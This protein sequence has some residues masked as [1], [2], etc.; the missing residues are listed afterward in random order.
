[1]ATTRFMKAAGVQM[2]RV[3]YRGAAQLM[4]DLMASR[5]QLNFGPLPSGLAQAREGKLRL[6]AVL[7]GQRSPLAPEVPTLAEAGVMGVTLPSWQAIFAPPRMPPEVAD[8]LSRELAAAL[9]DPSLRTALEQLSLRVEPSTAA[10]L[11]ALAARDAQ[12]WR[13]FV[14]E[15]DIAP[16]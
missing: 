1:M 13:S 10:A 16:E 7:G 12:T 14:A 2:T 15:Y 5:V 4:P 9:A 6:L 3:P 8:R 11:A